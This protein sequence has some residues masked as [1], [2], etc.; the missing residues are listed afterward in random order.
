MTRGDC[1]LVV[2]CHRI[3]GGHRGHHRDT[4]GTPQGHHRDTTGTPQGHPEP[5]DHNSAHQSPGRTDASQNDLPTH[6]LK[7]LPSISSATTI[8]MIEDHTLIPHAPRKVF[9][10]F[11]GGDYKW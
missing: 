4:T 10:E 3:F 9:H 5:K 8:K 11:A 6:N 1:S 2:P 7:M